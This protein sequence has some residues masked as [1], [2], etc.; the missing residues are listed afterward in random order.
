MFIGNFYPGTN[1]LQQEVGRMLNC[2]MPRSFELLA[3][4]FYET[5]RVPQF[6]VWRNADKLLVTSEL[7]GI[8]PENI[9][10]EVEGNLL[11][12]SADRA[13]EPSEG[14]NYH[15][16]ERNV[17]AYKRSIKLPFNVDEQSI[18]AQYQKGVLRISLT[19]AP[20]EKPKKIQVKSNV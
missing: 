17:G 7:P 9:S 6:N 1:E 19:Q 16:I 3:K 11:T 14:R 8:A 18:D 2:L 4:D 20:Q 13:P 5:S 12:V 10:V 15:R